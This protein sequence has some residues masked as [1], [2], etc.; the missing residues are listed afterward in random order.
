MDQTVSGASGTLSDSG[1]SRMIRR[2]GLIRRFS[3]RPQQFRWTGLWLQ[4]GGNV[5]QIQEALSEISGLVRLCQPFRQA[6]DELVPGIALSEYRKLVPLTRNARQGETIYARCAGHDTIRCDPGVAYRPREMTEAVI[7]DV[8]DLNA[9]A[10]SG[11]TAA[12]RFDF[13]A[14]RAVQHP[15]TAINPWVGATDLPALAGQTM[16]WAAP[17]RAVSRRRG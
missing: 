5:V 8:L 10:L 16:D 3:S 11:T 12:D 17:G 13:N 15:W 4:G 14:M 6:G 2:M 1:L 7:V 9:F